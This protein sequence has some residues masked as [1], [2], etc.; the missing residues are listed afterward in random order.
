MT[1]EKYSGFSIEELFDELEGLGYDDAWDILHLCSDETNEIVAKNC[2]N[3]NAKRA[4]QSIICGSG[5]GLPKK[6]SVRFKPIKIKRKTVYIAAFSLIL[7]L[8]VPSLIAVWLESRKSSTSAAPPG[9]APNMIHSDNNNSFDRPPLDNSSTV[10]TDNAVAITEQPPASTDDKDS[11]SET[12]G[13]FT[14]TEIIPTNTPEPEQSAYISPTVIISDIIE[15]SWVPHHGI[16]VGRF[17]KDFDIP[18]GTNPILADMIRDGDPMG[19]HALSVNFADYET[20]AR[21]FSRYYDPSGSLGN[22][23]T[24]WRLWVTDLEANPL[25]TSRPYAAGTGET[26]NLVVVLIPDNSFPHG[27]AINNNA[28]LGTQVVYIDGDGVVGV[29]VFRWAN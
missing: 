5:E 29:G 3:P 8:I 15:V 20:A 19:I 21:R 9:A 14:E 10:I 17:I 4:A 12:N 28:L 13:G 16:H 6:K 24:I 1:T 25:P 23:G 2:P 11:T 26:V 7:A 18:A 27:A 22:I